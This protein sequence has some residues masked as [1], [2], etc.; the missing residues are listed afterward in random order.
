MSILDLNGLLAGAGIRLEEEPEMTDGAFVGTITGFRRY[1]DLAPP[2]WVSLAHPYL[3]VAIGAVTAWFLASL[4]VI[5]GRHLLPTMPANGSSPPRE[6][7]FG[8]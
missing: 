6:H 4:L 3:L 2:E 7:R 5:W 8:D 1:E